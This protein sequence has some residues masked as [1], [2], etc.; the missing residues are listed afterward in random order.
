MASPSGEKETKCSSTQLCRNRVHMMLGFFVPLDECLE[1]INIRGRQGLRPHR[2][3]F[4]VPFTR[5]CVAFSSFVSASAISLAI[6]SFIDAPRLLLASACRD[7]GLRGSFSMRG[8]LLGATLGDDCHLL[9][10]RTF[11][12][13]LELKEH[14]ARSRLARDFAR[15]THIPNHRVA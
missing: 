2:H 12:R 1:E 15:T 11:A 5:L 3:R 6:G 7:E 14:L 9:P 13:E 10:R 8:H 4:H